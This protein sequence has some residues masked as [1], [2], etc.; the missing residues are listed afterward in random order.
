MKNNRKWYFVRHLCN[1]DTCSS[2]AE[3]EIQVLDRNGRAKH[4]GY[5]GH[6]ETELVIEG[7]VVPKEVLDAARRQ[8]MG[9]GDYVDSKGQSISPF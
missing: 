2:G 8:L 4:V 9:R 6:A 7:Q 5:C 1:E 3:F